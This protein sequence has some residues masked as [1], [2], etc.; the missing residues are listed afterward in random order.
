MRRLLHVNIEYT[1]IQVYNQ[2]VIEELYSHHPLC[3]NFLTVL[4]QKTLKDFQY[5]NRMYLNKTP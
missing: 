4:T 1:A 5:L 3:D 2:H